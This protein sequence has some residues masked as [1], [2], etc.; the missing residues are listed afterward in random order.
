MTLIRA[1][2]LSHKQS[3]V[4]CPAIWAS[5]DSRGS[6]R[7]R[8][9]NVHDLIAEYRVWQNEHEVRGRQQQRVCS[10]SRAAVPCP[11]AAQP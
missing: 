2:A 4:K 5:F 6:V 1:V 11:L 9:N 8:C 10:L 3:L 7:S